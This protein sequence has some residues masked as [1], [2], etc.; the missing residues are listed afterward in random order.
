MK[1]RKKTRALLGDR[2]SAVAQ[3]RMK[4]IAN[5]ASES[6]VNKKRKRGN[7]GKP[8]TIWPGC[9]VANVCITW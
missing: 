5:L 3:N 8:E 1:E 4:S 9:N 6:P 2:K 7:D